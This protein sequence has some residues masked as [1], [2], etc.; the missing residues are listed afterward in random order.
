[1]AANSDRFTVKSDQIPANV[2]DPILQKWGKYFTYEV[3]TPSG[4]S[5]GDETSIDER[6][7]DTEI[8]DDCY[9]DLHDVVF[10]DGKLTF[11]YMGSYELTSEPPSMPKNHKYYTS[12]IQTSSQKGDPRL[13]CFLEW[14]KSM[15]FAHHQYYALL[16]NRLDTV[17]SRNFKMLEVFQNSKLWEPLA[18]DYYC[19]KCRSPYLVM[20]PVKFTNPSTM[21]C[22]HCL[23]QNKTLDKFMALDDYIASLRKYMKRTENLFNNVVNFINQ[24]I[25]TEFEFEY[26]IASG[27]GVQLQCKLV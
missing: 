23:S 8:F 16:A 9:L 14:M 20:K 11:R 21:Y 1:M 19:A 26:K 6:F 27:R 25:P 24:D 15:L 22:S 4:I 17:E 2:F 18:I 13:V 7:Q 12:K 3:T 5:L 10:A